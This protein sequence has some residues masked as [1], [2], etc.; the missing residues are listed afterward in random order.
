M[1]KLITAAVLSA[2][3][4]TATALWM[5]NTKEE[6]SCRSGKHEREEEETEK[7]EFEGYKNFF[8]KIRGTSDDGSFTYADYYQARLDA[9]EFADAGSRGA[10]NIVWEEMG[11][12][13]QGGRSRALL[14]DRN[15]PNRLF[16]GG[17]SGGIWVSTNK[18]ASWTPVAGSE[19]YSNL[20]VS[21]IAQAGNGNIYFGTGEYFGFFEASNVNGATGF[22]GGGIWC[23]TD[24]GESFANILTPEYPA[25]GPTSGS[26]FA[27]IT[28]MRADPTDA[29]RVYFATNVTGATYKGIRIIN[30]ANN[31]FTNGGGSITGTG[32]DVEV[33]SDGTVHAIVNKKYYRS[34]PGGQN[35]VVV[36]ASSNLPQSN[37]SRLDIAVS[38]QDPNY[39]YAMATNT[40]S[41]GDVLRGIYK[42]ID[43]G[44]TFTTICGPTVP[45]SADW[46]P[47]TQGFYCID[48]AVHPTDK[49]MVIF[50]GLD[51]YRYTPQTGAKQISN[52]NYNFNS[53]SYVHADIHRFDFDP[54][55]P[56]NMYVL[57]DGGVNWT[58]NIRASQVNWATKNRNYITTQCYSVCAKNYTG[59]ILTG[60]QDNGNY[61]ID[62]QGN[63]SKWGV[64]IKGGDG[65]D[66]AISTIN[67]NIMFAEYVNGTVE[68]SSNN[69]AS[70]ANF[71]DCNIDFS[72]A[73]SSGGCGGDGEPDD[74]APFIAQLELWE[75][76]YEPD[77]LK[78]SKFFLGTNKALWMTQEPLNLLEIPKWFKVSKT[79]SGGGVLNGPV[80]AISVSKDG[81]IVYVGTESGSLYR[82]NGLDTV[83]TYT[84]NNGV[85]TFDPDSFNLTTTLLNNFGSRVVT[86]IDVSTTDPNVVVVTLGRYGQT[87][88]VFRSTNANGA[89]PTFTSIDGS[90]LP[91]MPV[92]CCIMD[93]LDN[94]KIMIGTELGV[95]STSNGGASWTIEDNGMP[96]VPVLKFY[97]HFL[98]DQ[99]NVILASS[100]GRGIFRTKSLQFTSIPEANGYKQGNNK[101]NV[102]PNPV[103]TNCNIS[104]TVPQTGDVELQMF[105]LDGKMVKSIHYNNMIPGT[106]YENIECSDLSNGTYIIR[107]AGKALNLSSKL[108]IIR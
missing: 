47:V 105:S 44:S 86:G 63:T 99:D 27:F 83:L 60:M 12:D 2:V 104:F 91:K 54:I 20:T 35:F 55:N 32:Q 51:V 108:V 50:G 95:Y 73:A 75:N 4:L 64:L 62:F 23:S 31:T 87:S 36:P 88:Y 72:P 79:T 9:K 45:N 68:R 21:C 38:P 80:S 90:G 84:N 49:D 66:V 34:A 59:E 10:L 7:G 58:S 15:N 29:N 61:Y 97:R 81:S 6:T 107:V 25:N 14:I 96:R 98:G 52:W 19:D 102:Y 94:N 33:A 8:N 39:V 28:A 42:S 100:Y 24:N 40:N 18:G 106:K 48:I 13:N 67:P 103:S 76:V 57:S 1:K 22:P 17:V 53:T 82:I 65:G 30:A 70:F 71:F 26:N 77:P 92:Y 101:L 89:S 41:A 78:K 56:D 16:C 74:G 93:K 5:N 46:N 43:G 37:L 85:L 3:V 11:P 69:G